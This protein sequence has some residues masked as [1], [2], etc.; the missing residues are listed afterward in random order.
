MGNHN[1]VID[2]FSAKAAQRKLRNLFAQICGVYDNPS[3][4]KG[5]LAFVLYAPGAPLDPT[6]LRSLIVLVTA[7][8]GTSHEVRI[9]QMEHDPSRCLYWLYSA[10][11]ALSIMDINGDE[12]ED[13][14]KMQIG[15]ESSCG[16][17]RF[18]GM[19]PIPSKR[20]K[21]A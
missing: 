13:A 20:R 2:L 12:D 10:P 21:Q 1:N 3:V 17:H 14:Q 8:D 16:N 11:A 18:S 9:A 5:K 4:I 6:L 7:P 19:P 15:L